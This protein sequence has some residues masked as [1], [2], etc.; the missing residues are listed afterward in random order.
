MILLVDGAGVYPKVLQT[1]M[2]CLV[3]A[4]EQL[5]E[6][7]LIGASAVFNVLK[8]DL[9]IR[10]SAPGVRQNSKGRRFVFMEQL[11]PETTVLIDL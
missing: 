1:I 11:R 10:C 5:L 3:T 9:I 4:E 7:R 8:F 2:L 6:G